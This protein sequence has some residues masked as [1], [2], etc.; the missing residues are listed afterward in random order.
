MDARKALKEAKRIVFKFGTNVVT[1]KTGDISI[2]TIGHLLE[3]IADLHDQGKEIIIVSSGAVGMGRKLLNLTDKPK[4]IALKQACAA[5]GQSSLMS[6]YEDGLEKMSIKAAQ[7]LLTEEDFS[8][9][10]RYLN[11][12]SAMHKLLELRVIPIVNENDVVSTSEI[13]IKEGDKER[14][15]CFGDNDKLSAIVMSKLDAD[16]LVI[17]SDIDGLYDA[18][19]AENPTAQVIKIVQSITTDIE[20]LCFQSTSN[21]SRGGMQTKLE[22]AK[23]AVNS[24]GIAV[25]ANG[26]EP[27][28]IDKIF[29]G[30]TIGTV[31]L[32]MAQL[33]SKKRWIAFASSICG[34]VIVNEGAKKALVKNHAS[35]LPAGVLNVNHCF[36][37]GDVVSIIDEQGTEFA[38]GIINYSSEEAFQLI[39]LQSTDIENVLSYKQN[40]ALIHCDNIVIL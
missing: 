14:K 18:N 38:R 3:S 17:L 29:S 10:R 4:T 25:I 37:A 30:E 35:L 19:P 6:F 39:G 28:I 20:D 12:R 11:L 36:E 22:A 21:R 1:R 33:S 5:I 9:R 13:E 7:V 40:D 24:G 32:P 34:E 16:V 27:H 23:V 2:G 8:N 31:F 15:A 26:K